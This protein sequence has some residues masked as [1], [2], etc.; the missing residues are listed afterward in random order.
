[1]DIKVVHRYSRLGRNFLHLA[2]GT[3]GVKLTGML[4]VFDDFSISKA[5]AC[6]V[7]N[8]L[9]KRASNPVKRV[10]LYTTGPFPGSLIGNRCWIGVVDDY[11]RYSW[12]FSM[13]K[14]S[15][16]PNKME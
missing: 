4:Q 16:L 5:K 7:I 3:L 13:K 9:Y 14:K 10:F 11:R 1:M 12:S 2:Y 8:N 15:Q 6:S